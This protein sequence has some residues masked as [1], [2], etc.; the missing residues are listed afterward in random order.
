MHTASKWYR[1][2][3]TFLNIKRNTCIKTKHLFRGSFKQ[4]YAYQ[5]GTV[6]T[7]EYSFIRNLYSIC[8]ASIKKQ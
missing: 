8:N 5:E 7:A 6:R 1:I 4:Y 3:L 2:N